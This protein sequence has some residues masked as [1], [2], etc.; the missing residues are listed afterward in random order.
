MLT[1][2]GSKLPPTTRCDVAV[3]LD[4]DTHKLTERIVT[5]PDSRS[6]SYRA[7]TWRSRSHFCRT[8]HRS[9]TLTWEQATTKIKTNQ[10]QTKT[11][12]SLWFFDF[13]KIFWLF[14]FFLVIFWLFF[15]SFFF[16]DFFSSFLQNTLLIPC[17][18]FVPPYVVKV[19][20]AAQAGCCLWTLSCDFCP[21]QLTKHYHGSHR[22]PTSRKSH[23]GGDSVAWSTASLFGGY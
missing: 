19:T 21:A 22:C 15:F 3:T 8:R 6:W 23:S 1:H 18:E 5:Y 11:W 12:L 16:L 2:R 9:W 4:T 13:F 20:G 17:E 10:Q 14:F 7:G